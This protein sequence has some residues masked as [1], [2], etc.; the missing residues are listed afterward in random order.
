MTATVIA[1]VSARADGLR[2]KCLIRNCTSAAS[3][4]GFCRDCFEVVHG[5]A[6]DIRLHAWARERRRIWRD[7]L[8]RWI[9]PRTCFVLLVV[10]LLE[11]LAILAFPYRFIDA[12]LWIGGAR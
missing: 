5:E 9:G 1:T 3:R 11:Y 4:C 7:R 10:L 2:A 6:E 12:V 8:A